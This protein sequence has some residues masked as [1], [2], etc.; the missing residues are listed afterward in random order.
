[1]SKYELID[2][3]FD[4]DGVCV[5]LT[6]RQ[7]KNGLYHYS[8]RFVR[9]YPGKGGEEMKTTWLSPRHIPAIV[10]L[11]QK[12]DERLK[13]EAD[14]APARKKRRVKVGLSGTMA[15]VARLS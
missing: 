13:L 1:M 2:T 15:E 10:R 3:I 11:T 14:R 6:R 8:Y 12:A 9:S 5:E 7:N 4:D